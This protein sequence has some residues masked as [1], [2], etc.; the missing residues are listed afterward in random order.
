MQSWCI[1]LKL[2]VLLKLTKNF[3]LWVVVMIQT[4]EKGSVVPLPF[5]YSLLEF[6]MSC[7]VSRNLST[8]AFPCSQKM[9]IINYI[10]LAW[11]HSTVPQTAVSS[12][13]CSDFGVALPV[14]E[15]NTCSVVE[16][17][18]FH[19]KMLRVSLRNVLSSTKYMM[20]SV[21]LLSAARRNRQ[22]FS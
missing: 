4:C 13:C 16:F 3:L 20:G 14:P 5:S 19:L 2:T 8:F 21:E 10:T 22:F 17:F 12:F 11:L 1:W 18:W 6:F 15:Q 7:F 9:S